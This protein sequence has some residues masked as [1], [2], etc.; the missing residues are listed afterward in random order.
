MSKHTPRDPHQPPLVAR[1]RAYF[2]R[3]LQTMLGALGRMTR[4]PFASLMTVAVIGIALALPAA[5]H[6]LV[7][8][9]K[10]LAGNFET[11]ADV[12]VYLALPT[13]R[14]RVDALVDELRDWPEIAS[15][16]T[17]YADAALAEFAELSG[18]G[19]AL[20]AL[21]DNPLPHTL[22]I[23]PGSGYT[24]P[25][26]LANLAEALGRVPDADL[27][28]ID[29][30]W[31]ERF[32][33][34]LELVRRAVGLSATLL[35]LAVV[36]I[37]GN[38]IRLDIENRRSEIEVTKLVGASDA[39]V[40]RP[41][42]YSGLWYGL[43]GGL[44]ASL[45]VIVGLLLLRAP[46]AQLAGLYGSGFSLVGPGFDGLGA[47]VGGGAALGWLG[48]WTATTRHLRRIEPV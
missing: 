39:F 45:L 20:E 31:I 4:H 3:H 33:A 13:E 19:V 43:G 12:T 37:V 1:V 26:A 44:L 18:F 15:I 9:G 46:V 28:Q 32:H 24:G 5:L 2:V 22:V 21:P 34:I 14:P 27:V 41:F 6:L 30:D 16:R 8:N 29:T 47:L 23:T 36:L 35:A 42:L 38:T 7:V 25:D 17:I 40:R 10:A 48:S 11:V